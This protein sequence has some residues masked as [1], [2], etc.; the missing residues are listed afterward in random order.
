M[1]N[2]ILLFWLAIALEMM[3]LGLAISKIITFLTFIIGVIF[4][5]SSLA[6]LKFFTDIPKNR[7]EGE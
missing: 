3:L 6:I 4:V 1:D 7:K 2:T 5:A